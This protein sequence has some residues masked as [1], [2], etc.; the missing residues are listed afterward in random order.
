MLCI[1]DAVF[2]VRYAT[3]ISILS[4]Y[5]TKFFEMTIKTLSQQ[6][7]AAELAA[8]AST[9]TEAVSQYSKATSQHEQNTALKTITSNS[10]KLSQ[11]A[12]G[13][14]LSLTAFHFKPHEVLCVRL[15]I[16]M[17]L[18]DNL[19]I[20]DSFTV[21]YVAGKA[22]ADLEFTGRL[23]RALAAS[24]IFEEVGEGTY[25][26]T[27]LSQE[28][29]SKYMQSY[30]KY[31]WDYALGSMSSFMDFFNTTGFVSPSDPLNTPYAFAK[32]A[33]DIDFFSLLQQDHK[34]AT[35]FNEAMTS[36]KD[37]LGDLYDFG[38]LQTPEGGVVLVDI[39]GGKG[40]SI[41]SV[42]ST[43]PNLKGRYVL[44]DLPGVLEAGN[45]VCSPDVEIQPYNFFEQVQPVE[46]EYSI[47]VCFDRIRKIV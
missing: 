43:Y 45:R 25:K 3:Y 24:N 13:P 35:T 40:Q 20:S 36:M 7:S 33:K 16:E 21:K 30:T 10:Q 42:C 22:G 5:N 1:V 17:G 4:N 26:Q 19:P 6:P 31:S 15:A 14:R 27:A 38:S 47:F 34:A 9:I 39:G 29:N 23:M 18:F 46:G 11:C 2:I 41:E 37:R 28:W 8:F 12:M 32:G 44:Q